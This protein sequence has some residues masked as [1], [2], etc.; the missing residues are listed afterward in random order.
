MSILC[1]R[2]KTE[3]EHT[4]RCRKC[5]DLVDISIRLYSTDDEDPI[6][7]DSMEVLWHPDVKMWSENFACSICSF[8]PTRFTSSLSD[9]AYDL[10][11]RSF[12]LVGH[13]AK[14]TREAI[15][16]MSPKELRTLAREE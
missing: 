1:P 7:D 16:Y 10:I 8:G 3:N 6:A 13:E 14:L 9:R 5:W 15:V 2:C 11:I 12:G 4:G